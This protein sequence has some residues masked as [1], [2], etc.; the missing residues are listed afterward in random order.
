MTVRYT[1]TFRD[2]MAFCFHQY[3]RSPLIL[4]AYVCFSLYVGIDLAVSMPGGLSVHK[5]VTILIADLGLLGLLTGLYAVSI[6]TSMIS[7]RN[8]TLLTEHVLTLSDECLVEETVYNKTELKWPGVQKLTRT[9]GHI[10]IY[11]AQHAAHA[12]PRRAFRDDSEWD[13][14]YGFCQRQTEKA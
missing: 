6:V 1:N 9:R 14:F 4:G 13:A 2:I 3:S 12:V 7:R 10:F 5:A 8:K 11:V